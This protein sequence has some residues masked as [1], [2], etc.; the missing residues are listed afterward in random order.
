MC[1]L[2]QLCK[3]GSVVAPSGGVLQVLAERVG[4]RR[5]GRVEVLQGQLGTAQAQEE[6]DEEQ[7]GRDMQVSTALI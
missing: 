5:E 2:L 6:E 7:R 4:Q 1:N 3:S